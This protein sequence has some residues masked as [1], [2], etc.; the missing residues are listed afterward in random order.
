MLRKTLTICLLAGTTVALAQGP[1]VINSDS[2][3]FYLQKGIAEKQTGRLQASLKYFEKAGAFEP[4]NKAALT[5]LA[6]TTL[7]CGNTINPKK[8]TNNSMPWVVRMQL[9]TNSWLIFRSISNNPMMFCCM[10]VN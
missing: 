8:H 2:S 3:S 7:N 1:A 6:V 10:Q 5:Q 4:S 9:P